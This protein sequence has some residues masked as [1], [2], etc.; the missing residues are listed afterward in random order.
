MKENCG[1]VLMGFFDAPISELNRCR[2]EVV[3]PAT[4]LSAEV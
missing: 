1:F 3:V 4:E 2:S